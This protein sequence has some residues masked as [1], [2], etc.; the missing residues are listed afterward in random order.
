L[1]PSIVEEIVNASPALQYV[2]DIA[3]RAKHGVLRESRSGQFAELVDVGFTVPQSAV[4]KITVCAFSVGV[5]ICNSN[6][7][8]LRGSV[9]PRDAPA[10]DAFA[11]LN[12]ALSAWEEHALKKLAA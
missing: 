7:V 4:S 6:E 1:D 12:E 9:L 3:N 10:L 5:D 11:V 2:A 8:T